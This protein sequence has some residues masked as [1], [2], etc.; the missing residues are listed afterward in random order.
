MRKIVFAALAAATLASAAGGAGAQAYGGHRW[1]NAGQQGGVNQRQAEF[2][3]RIDWGVRTGALTRGEAATLRAQFNDI[4]RLE[5]RY[6]VGGLSAWERRD[7]DVRLDRLDVQ[8]R[9]QL[10]DGQIRHAHRR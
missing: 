6:R 4:A 5:A 7:L 10:H 9:Q 3:N 2:D 8:I 1:D